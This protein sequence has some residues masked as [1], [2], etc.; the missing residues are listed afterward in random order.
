MD[1]LACDIPAYE[2]YRLRTRSSRHA[3]VIPI[4]N[5]APRIHNQLARMHDY[6]VDVILVD[7]G[8]ADGSADSHVL[9]DLGVTTLLIKTGMGRLAA[10]ERIGF[11]WALNQ[12]YD[13]IIRMDGN[14]KDDPAGIPVIIAA[15]ERGFDF[16]QG[17][18]FIPGGMEENTPLMRR[19]AI[20]LVH[21][22][23]V[24]FLA[25]EKFTDTTNAFRGHSRRYLEHP[26]VQPFRDIFD[27]YE[28]LAYL[29]VR[30]SQIGLQT[31]EVPVVRRYPP[32]E[33]PTKI[34][35]VRGNIELIRT[36]V[37]LSKGVFNP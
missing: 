2:S 5:E 29:S 35:H 13:G 8:S 32:G 14:D 28:L 20:Q 10:Q 26:A 15:L 19:V 7:G 17:S 12:G 6:D 34:S 18:R 23:W 27:S 31:C 30:A 33:V 21:A 22:P 1:E 37:R 11:A 9:D 25:D 4:L 3:V 24:S 36:L 16:V